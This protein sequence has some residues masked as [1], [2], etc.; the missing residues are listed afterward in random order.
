MTAPSDGPTGRDARIGRCQDTQSRF[1]SGTALPPNVRHAGRG[2][3]D[4]YQRI[5]RSCAPN[6]VIGLGDRL[7]HDLGAWGKFLHGGGHI[8]GGMN[9]GEPIPQPAMRGPP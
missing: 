7:D 2:R 3:I 4:R 9:D 6:L 5:N 1:F 8:G